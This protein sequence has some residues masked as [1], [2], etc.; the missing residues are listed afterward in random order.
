VVIF[1]GTVIGSDGFGYIQHEGRHYKIPQRGEVVIEDEVE[2]GA[3][4][5]IDRATHGQTVIGRATKVDNQVHIAHNVTI[6]EH[7]L[8]VAQVGI[9]GS[10][11]VGRRVVMG[12][13][14][15]VADHLRIGDGAMIAAS[16]GVARDVPA[17]ERVSGTPALPHAEAVRAY[18]ALRHLPELRQRLRE[19]ERRVGSLENAAET[20]S[21]RTQGRPRA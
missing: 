7:T 15:G 9:A 2:L 20:V 14:A 6:G 16:A 11:A 21:P 10:T 8:L 3:N 1:S 5:T 12:G 13:Q 19:L 17:G 4:V 18:T